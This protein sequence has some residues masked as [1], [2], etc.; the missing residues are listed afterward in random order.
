MTVVLGWKNLGN[1]LSKHVSNHG[2]SSS[3]VDF[4]ATDKVMEL[5]KQ[6]RKIMFSCQT[7]Q[8]FIVLD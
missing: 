5:L 1:P 2:S 7:I 8:A 4:G 6:S 3:Q